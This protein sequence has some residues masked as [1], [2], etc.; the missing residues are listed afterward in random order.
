MDQE[1]KRGVKQNALTSLFTFHSNLSLNSSSVHEPMA[2][3]GLVSVSVTKL[4][5]QTA[6]TWLSTIS[7]VWCSPPFL[8]ACIYFSPLLPSHSKVLGPPDS[9]RL[10]HLCGGP[11]AAHWGA[12]FTSTQNDASGA[13]PTPFNT[14]YQ[15]SQSLHVSHAPYTFPALWQTVIY[16]SPLCVCAC[17]CTGRLGDIE[18]WCSGAFYLLSFCM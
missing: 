16:S 8:K 11:A 12:I 5:L 13:R 2:L 1:L 6:S 18:V 7:D 9:R 15:W 14:V 3:G 4:R 10:T 17:V